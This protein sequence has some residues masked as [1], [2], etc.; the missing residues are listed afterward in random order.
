[1]MSKNVKQYLISCPTLVLRYVSLNILSE[2]TLTVRNC[3]VLMFDFEKASQ[4]IKD[5]GCYQGRKIQGVK[6]SCLSMDN[7]RANNQN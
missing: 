1:M 2:K 3:L 5:S 4:R 7:L 6:G